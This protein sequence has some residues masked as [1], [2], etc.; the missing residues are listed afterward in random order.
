M[1]FFVQATYGW[2]LPRSKSLFA[3]CRQIM[4]KQEV[5]PDS[6]F[7]K[8]MHDP[9]AKLSLNSTQLQLKLRLRLALVPVDPATHPPTHPPTW[10]SSF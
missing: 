4:F 8:K 7:Q 3:E 9:F 6:F 5:L 10:D 1:A 2:I